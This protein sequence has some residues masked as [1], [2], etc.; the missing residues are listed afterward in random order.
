[1]PIPAKSVLIVD[2]N[3]GVRAALRA[4]LRNR[5]GIRVCAE[6][7][8]GTDGVNK[9]REYKPD[10]VLMDVVMP[11]LNGFEAAAAMR[12][13]LPKTRIVVF[14]M[15]GDIVGEALARAVGVDLIVSKQ[16]T[17]VLMQQLQ[18][19]LDSSRIC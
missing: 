12:K 18:A 4:F 16:N 5:E 6:A 2:D 1:M 11:N 9:A 13:L 19:L 17:D 8:D 7:V 3:P 15:F 10:L 14:T